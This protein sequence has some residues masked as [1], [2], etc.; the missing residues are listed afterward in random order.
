MLDNKRLLFTVTALAIAGVLILLAYSTSLD[1]L[2]LAIGEIDRS[3]EGSIVITVGTVTAARTFTDGAITL[4]LSDMN[5]SASVS[6]YIPAG[7]PESPANMTM[8]PGAVLSVRGEVAFYLESPE[9]KVAKAGDISVL[10][11]PGTSEYRLDTVMGAIALFD[12]LETTTTGTAIDMVV[13]SSS[14]N[15][16]GTTFRL[17]EVLDNQ[18]YYLECICFDRDLTAQHDDW[19][20]VR[21]TGTILYAENQGR[22]QMSVE[23]I[24][25]A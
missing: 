5:T 9:I 11:E 23:I 6:V 10:A 22:W 12:G 20:R 17:R 2:E 25:A 1:A 7:M 24:S 13:M 18:T 14:T 8:T 4:T 21:V 16:V 19:D 15:L 3:H